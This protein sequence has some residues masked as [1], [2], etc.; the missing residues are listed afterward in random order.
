MSTSIP[1]SGLD[2][3]SQVSSSDY[4]AVVQNSTTTTFKS[5]L[6]T[7]GNWISSS[8][9]SSSSLSSISSSYSNNSNI[10]NTSSLSNS[11]SYLIYSS[12]NGT[13]SYAISSSHSITAS[14]AQ[15]VAGGTF[16]SVSSSWSSASLFSTSA[17]FASQSI[18][19]SYSNNSN[20]ASY[21]KFS[22]SASYASSSLSS[23][24]SITAS[25]S[26]TSS[27]ALNAGQT[28]Y[29]VAIPF[30]SSTAISTSVQLIPGVWQFLLDSRYE[31]PDGSPSYAYTNTQSASFSTYIVSSSVVYQKQGGSGYGRNIYGNQI[32]GK[33]FTI[34][35][36]LNGTMVLYP[37]I[38]G[39][40]S[41]NGSSV[42]NGSS[43]TLIKIA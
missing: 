27:Y 38:L 26:N 12:N 28:F 40:P 14:F 31:F 22:T 34:A 10:S 4:L 16:S 25:F 17:S 42:S 18:S 7:V 35:S 6:L 9:Q 41:G 24:Y 15:A 19:S 23:S 3:L 5:T 43:A 36:P 13:A 39:R 29:M 32:V 33:T 20:S 37:P 11:S 8:I 21:S 2:V 30:G 1:I